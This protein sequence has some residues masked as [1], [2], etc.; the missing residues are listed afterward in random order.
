MGG[1]YNVYSVNGQRTFHY[2][3]TCGKCRQTTPWMSERI[4][5]EHTIQTKSALTAQMQ[6]QLEDG[7][8]KKLND[9]IDALKRYTAAGHYFTHPLKAQYQYY[10]VT[11]C[12]SCG[13]QPK[14]KGAIL[15]A[16]I[17]CGI[18]GLFAGMITSV[19]LAWL[20]IVESFPPMIALTCAT[21][22]AGAVIGALTESKRERKGAIHTNVEYRWDEEI[23][24]AKPQ[25]PGN[26]VVS[27]KV[28]ITEKINSS[29]NSGPDNFKRAMNMTFSKYASNTEISTKTEEALKDINDIDL[30]ANLASGAASNC[31]RGKASHKRRELLREKR[32]MEVKTLRDQTE[33]IRI[34]D[35]CAEDSY[36]REFIISELIT[37]KNALSHFAKKD[38]GEA[39]I[40]NKNIDRQILLDIVIYSVYASDA[41]KGAYRKLKDLNASETSAII[42]NSVHTGLSEKLLKKTE[43]QSL[44]KEVFQAPGRADLAIRNMIYEKLENHDLEISRKIKEILDKRINDRSTFEKCNGRATLIEE[45]LEL[46]KKDEFAARGFWESLKLENERSNHCHIPGNSEGGEDDWYFLNYNLEN[47]PPYPF[48]DA[49][50]EGR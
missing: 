27:D 19:V 26:K 6:R 9:H 44:L 21:I 2:R 29:T 31:V 36:I 42:L 49:N 4:K 43:D 28:E 25:A 8:T 33:L 14:L 13:Q 24:P 7:L 23:P 38:Y 20:Y 48:D 17:I 39:V 45:L 35:D 41:A 11:K 22:L 50:K 46:L 32:K 18:I 5:A 3:F 16:S 47:F 40:M 12:P 1:Y 34:A 10:L 37:D 15:E 30:L